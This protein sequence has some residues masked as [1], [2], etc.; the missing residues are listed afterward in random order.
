MQFICLSLLETVYERA[1]PWTGDSTGGFAELN[2]RNDLYNEV[3]K[4]DISLLLACS[5]LT[6]LVHILMM[7]LKQKL[8]RVLAG[9]NDYLIKHLQ[10]R[11]FSCTGFDFI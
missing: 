10:T 1:C 3:V 6:W 5:V 11:E 2:S 4:A 7:R 8:A 9:S